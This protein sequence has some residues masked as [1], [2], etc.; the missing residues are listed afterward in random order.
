[1]NYI[2][3]YISNVLLYEKNFI[4]NEK[5]KE[6][7]FTL[8]PLLDKSKKSSPSQQYNIFL[9]KLPDDANWL[10]FT[11]D[12]LRFLEDPF[13]N[14]PD[15]SVNSLYGVIGARIATNGLGEF[16]KECQG[17][18]LVQ[19]GTAPS[20]H[21]YNDS[22]APGENRLVDTLDSICLITQ[23]RLF[24]Q[25]PL[26]FDPDLR[27]LHGEDL[28][29]QAFDSHGIPSKVVPLKSCLYG[30]LFLPSDQIETD[31]TKC[32]TKYSD[33]KPRAGLHNVFYSKN[34]DFDCIFLTKQ[35]QEK[36]K[37]YTFP[38]TTANCNA[39]VVVALPMMRNGSRVLDVG[40]ACGDNG[41]FLVETLQAEMYG[42]DYSDESLALAAEK[43]GTY[44]ELHNADLNTLSPS[45]F[46]NYYH[47]FDHILLLDVLEHLYAPELILQK[48]K[49]Y[50]NKNGTIIFSVPN[51]GHA[52]PAL[53]LMQ[54]DFTYSDFGIM[55]STHVRFFTWKSLA[56]SLAK[57]GFKIISS[58]VAFRGPDDSHTY[59]PKTLPQAIYQYVRD[60]MHMFVC[61][62]VCSII[63]S[64]DEYEELKANN[65][66]ELEN[67]IH[68]NEKGMQLI[69]DAIQIFYRKVALAHGGGYSQEKEQRILQ[70]IRANKFIDAILYSDFFDEL[71]YRKEY[72]EVDFTNQHPLQHYLNQGWREGKSPSE[73]FDSKWILERYPIVAQSKT[74]PLLFYLGLGLNSRLHYNKACL[75]IPEQ[76]LTKYSNHVLTQ[77]DGYKKTF[78]NIS[79][80]D[81]SPD[82]N[83]ARLIAFY[84]PQFSP[85]PENDQWWGK[86][87]TEWTNVTKAVPQ[88]VGHYQPHLPYDLGFYDLR[89]RETRLRQE[90]L[91]KKYGVHG[92]CYHYYWFDGQKV[93]AGPIQ[94]KLQDKDLD[95]PFCLSW[96]NES[97]SANWDGSKDNLL[98]DQPEKINIERLFNDLLPFFLDH[99]YISIN[100]KKFFMIYR[101]G[102]FSAD[103][104]RQLVHGL[105]RLA[106][107]HGFDLHIVLG[108]TFR[109]HE[110]RL[111]LE[112]YGADAFIDFPPHQF[113]MQETYDETICNPRFVGRLF[114]LPD[115]IAMYKKQKRSGE[116][117]YRTVFPMWDNTSRKAESGAIIFKNALPE[118]YLDWLTFCIRA[119]KASFG[120]ER[121]VVF[122]NAW[123]EWA[124][125]AHLEPDRKYGYAFL[126]MTRRALE[127]TRQR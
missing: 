75:D 95:L 104:M 2:I 106:N 94:N 20:Y 83:D 53:N 51:V 93:M 78:V 64:D 56:V 113:T 26:C 16:M 80:R 43:T 9:E 10:I 30:D 90:E 89:V 70:K 125:G 98:I 34:N 86:G 55:D 45:D 27:S 110:K 33:S 4:E 126:E 41:L 58:S 21:I 107:K 81:Y 44:R 102:Y 115:L 15:S 92:F 12:R 85:F 50:L 6:S 40:C 46:S 29:L 105:R 54:Q 39:P 19:N 18:V 47:M 101:P 49:L 73:F 122:I 36:G 96:A 74:C 3:C 68:N 108:N 52:Q 11:H 114:N 84:L 66:L 62:Y 37:V 57:W 8:V 61:Q 97:W 123:N 31:L 14:L 17:E 38:V 72:N 28:C 1:M 42:M 79:T 59:V 24:R 91:A 118:V 69:T 124:E 60:N 99:R 63:P 48:L 25:Y 116:A 103:I 100:N 121:S 76:E 77:E 127:L 67:S 32:A 5:L 88:F 111:S 82:P 23:A 22:L 7:D 120:P 117:T 35:Y 71:W 109:D 87:F 65:L 119:T 112:E 13:T